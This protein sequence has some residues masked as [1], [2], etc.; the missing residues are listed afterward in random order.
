MQ[1]FRGNAAAE[2]S[3]YETLEATD[4][5]PDDRFGRALA[6]YKGGNDLDPYT[7]AVGAPGHSEERG[8]VYLFALQGLDFNPIAKI[9]A[10]NL[11]VGINF[12]DAAAF[13]P[14]GKTLA[15]T[16]GRDRLA[17][18]ACG[19]GTGPGNVYL[20]KRT[21]EFG[22]VF[23]AELSGIIPTQFGTSGIGTSLTFVPGLP[24]SQP[25]EL[26]VGTDAAPNSSGEPTGAVY[27]LREITPGNWTLSYTISAPS[28]GGVF[29]SFG[30]SMAI[31]PNGTRL[32]VGAPTTRAGKPGVPEGQVGAAHHLTRVSGAWTNPTRLSAL[33]SSATFLMGDMAT[34]VN[35]ETLA[36]GTNPST[37][38]LYRGI[39]PYEELR[40]PSYINDG[41]ADPPL[42]NIGSLA[43]INETVAC[44][45]PL[46][47]SSG[48][49]TAGSVLLFDAGVGKFGSSDPAPLANFGAAVAAFNQIAVVGQPGANAG[50]L[51]GHDTGLVQFFQ[52]STTNGTWTRI[53]SVPS[54]L[55][56]VPPATPFH[57]FGA[58]LAFPVANRVAVGAPDWSA[59]SGSLALPQ[60]GAVA[61]LLGNSTGTVWNP[62][63]QLPYPVKSP[64]QAGERV[65][66]SVAAVKSGNFLFIAAGAPDFRGSELQSGRV[67]VWR[68]P[69]GGNASQFVRIQTI[70]AQVPQAGARFG[71]ALAMEAY[72]DG[73]ID[74]WTAAPSEDVP[75]ILPG[76]VFTDA[77][78][79]YL[80]RKSS[81]SSTFTALN[82]GVRHANVS[83][84]SQ[85][86]SAL[87]LKGSAL[88][89]GAPLAGNVA[90]PDGGRVYGW[91]RGT[92]GLWSQVANPFLGTSNGG[93]LGT[94]LAT[95]GTTVIVG[96]PGA[97]PSGI[98]P[99]SGRVRTIRFTS[100]GFASVSTTTYAGA[101]PA[102]SFGSSVAFGNGTGNLPTVVGS[103]AND[104]GDIDSAG[105]AVGFATPLDACVADVDVDFLVGPTD[106]AMVIAEWGMQDLGRT[107]AD[108]NDDGQ[109]DG[110]DL[111]MV[112][113]SWDACIDG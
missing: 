107:R 58:S 44:G 88:A 72:S 96:E 90:A 49:N 76:S 102:D 56:T 87:A 109:V 32:C 6:V 46:S 55:P 19:P 4:A 26:L 10:P 18:P 23:S 108:I 106:I 95:N 7:I 94:S 84:G 75:G 14:D 3:L 91:R 41:S 63:G 31:S 25:P 66:S 39:V 110:V 50:Q 70:E 52:R 17:C 43:S 57:R 29:Q 15:I 47:S 89:V 111:A 21:P 24:A 93:R 27:V 8:A 71:A 51:P 98:V 13:S 73:S 100:I 65:G 97:N 59:G 22:W 45:L 79:I 69:L 83:A 38:T 53:A 67:H 68:G 78:S 112:L 28:D 103:P 74:L 99:N 30:R 82:T 101:R 1:V 86:G 62:G 81:Q 36:V 9:M 20:Y 54:P 34:F 64:P 2:W 80:H 105:M 5:S 113:S 92:T 35:D 37:V 33:G 16:A 77:G 12:G 61:L 85:Y 104:H 40:N 60:C 42:R 11:P 48:V